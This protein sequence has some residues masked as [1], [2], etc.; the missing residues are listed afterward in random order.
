M[1]NRC[2]GV[3]KVDGTDEA[4]KCPEPEWEPYPDSV[5]VWD[6]EVNNGEEAEVGDYVLED[7]D[8]VGKSTDWRNG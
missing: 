1:E 3:Y 5:L 8:L 7:E 6:M 2:I 4:V